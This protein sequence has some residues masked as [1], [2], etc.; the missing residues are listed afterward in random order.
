MF[1]KAL[2][3]AAVATAATGVQAKTPTLE[4]LYE[5]V[6]AQQAEIQRLKGQLG[7]TEAKVE[8]TDAKVEAT[9]DALE[10]GTGSYAANDGAWY[11]KTSLGGYGEHHYNH[12]DSDS[13]KT[14]QVDAH[15]FVLF[16]GHEFNDKLR[17]FSE[18]ELEHS[19]SGEGKPG[20]VELEQAYIEYDFAQ[21][22][23]AQIGQFLIPV[24]IINETHEPD[25]FYGVER[26]NVE[27]NIIPATWWETGVQVKGEL[28]PGLSYNLAVHSGLATDD[29][30]KIRGGRQKSAKANAEDFAYT[31]RIKYTGIQG[32]ELAA[33]VQ[34][35]EDVTQ[36]LFGQND[37]MLYEAH[38]VYQFDAFKFTGLWAKWDIDGLSFED[39]GRDEQ[40]GW[41]VEGAYKVTDKLGLFVR[42]SAWDNNAGNSADTETRQF[43]YGINYWLADNVVL[44]ADVANQRGAG[45]ADAFNLGV[46]W[47]F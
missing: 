7:E 16:V 38:A 3:A 39:A 8:K 13:G 44:K 6:Q 45:K 24:G 29:A 2:L 42:E 12:F 4:E 5:L 18:L 20:E 14:D 35:Q 30:G 40:E 17:F 23:S 43:D 10:K 34:Y 32:L 41:Y 37:A 11:N 15:R 1:K 26:N 47:S 27:K 31:G 22:H 28:A 46:G 21:N 19:L 9:A 36:D 33:T 25:T